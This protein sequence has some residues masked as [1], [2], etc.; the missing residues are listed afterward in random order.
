MEGEGA[1]MAIEGLGKTWGRAEYAGGMPV[2]TMAYELRSSR[3]VLRMTGSILVAG[4]RAVQC[5]LT[6]M[7]AI[8]PVGKIRRRIGR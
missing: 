5:E 4:E 3:A 8:D 1:G 2:W 6:D 7:G